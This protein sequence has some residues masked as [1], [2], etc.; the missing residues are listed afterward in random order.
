MFLLQAKAVEGATTFAGSSAQ[1]STEIDAQIP[2]FGG[3]QASNGGI[4][5]SDPA[6]WTSA[7][8]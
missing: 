8:A 3:T 7:N 1:V 5:A 2:T 6:G 4:R